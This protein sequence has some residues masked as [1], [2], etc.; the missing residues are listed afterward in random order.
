LQKRV[1]EE[2]ER[3][4]Q[5]SGWAAHRT[6]QALG[7]S[8]R[9]YYRWLKEEAWAKAVPAD[10]V[11]PVQMY[12]ALSAEKEAVLAYAR[13][14]PELRH[15]E[16]AWRMVDED[17]ACLSP[18]T[19]YRILKEANLVCPWRRRSKRRRA[20]VE[21]PARPD[22]RWVTD[23]MQVVV[24]GM[25]YYLVSFMDEYSRYIVHH[26]VL[27]G[28]DGKT[29]SLAAQAAID[30][31]AKGED[32]RPVAKPVIQSDNG[33][34]Y[35]AREFLA[36]LSEN[37]LGH[38]RIKPHCPEENGTMERAYRTLR[39]ALEDEELINLLQARDVLA[40][41][42]KWYNQERLHSALGYLPP[43]VYYRGNPAARHEERR[44]KMTEARH[45]RKETNLELRQRTIP[46]SAKEPVDS[47]VDLCQ[48]G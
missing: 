2:V 26:E 35:I 9:S 7:V 21:R 20:E 43:A 11:P 25:V 39:E 45:R 41:V 37:G 5:R 28:M 1:H 38:H 34:G 27:T 14:H 36:V 22:E 24:D 32:G 17:V 4:E 33:S 8:R 48:I 3:T 15:R 31:L 46:Y 19:V 30:R 40:K 18:S 29:V 16:L 23:L 42:V 47:E 12:E 44:R 13:A 6:L 10:P